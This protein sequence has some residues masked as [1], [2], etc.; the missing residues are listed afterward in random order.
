MRVASLAI[1]IVSTAIAASA[2]ELTLDRFAIEQALAIGQSRSDAERA[3]IHKPYRLAS[4]RPPVDF[5]EVITPFRRIALT[6]EARTR[7]GDRSFS[8]REAMAVLAE[9]E[10]RVELWVELTFHPLN[11]F[12]GVPDYTVTLLKADG[13]RMAP[14][15][16]DRIPRH[17]PRVE[18]GFLPLPSTLA[19]PAGGGGQPMVGGAMIARFD[20]R[21]LDAQGAYDVLVAEA[22]KE[23]ARARVDFAQ[24]R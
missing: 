3:R 15:R 16:V 9:S 5:I 6:A 1:C 4:T 18:G 21:T 19:A 23:L 2:L 12:I 24:L 8:Q 22:G 11:T 20:G 14:V 10:D 13:S 7:V 17:G